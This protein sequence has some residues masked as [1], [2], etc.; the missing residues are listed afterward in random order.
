MILGCLSLP[1]RLLG[2]AVLA[3]VL[4]LGWINRDQVRRWVNRATAD[5]PV[6]PAEVIP[7]TELTARARA[8]LDSLSRQ[9]AD[10][11]VLAPAEVQALVMGELEQR[12]AGM[13]DSV[14][15]TLSDGEVAVR[16]RVDADKLPSGSL[17]PLAEWIKGRQTVQV[18]GPL[19]LLR[20]GTGEWR[21]EQVTV[22]GLPMPRAVW[23]RMIELVIPGS[24]GSVVFPV[25]RWIT[26]IRV[27]PQG[28]VLYGERGR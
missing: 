3:A 5:A 18:H 6:P 9:R 10:S 11:V 8:R 25:D 15:V 7:A 27:T 12:A 22:R 21:I 19:N 24:K 17:G 1:F 26:G 14:T 2:L 4:Y 16:A 28:A 20:L 13:A 23:E